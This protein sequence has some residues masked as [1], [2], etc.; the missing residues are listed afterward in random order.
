MFCFLL[1]LLL[2]INIWIKKDSPQL[3]NNFG[4]RIEELAL[5]SVYYE[6]LPFSFFFCLYKSK[7][8]NE[9]WNKERKEYWM[10][11]PFFFYLLYFVYIFDLFII[12]LLLSDILSGYCRSHLSSGYFYNRPFFFLLIHHFLWIHMERRKIRRIHYFIEIYVTITV[13]LNQMFFVFYVDDE[14]SCCVLL[15]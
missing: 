2:K 4:N 3:V 11:N 8:R 15:L 14:C 1:L 12:E 6:F 5:V 13:A 7:L 10:K 9:E